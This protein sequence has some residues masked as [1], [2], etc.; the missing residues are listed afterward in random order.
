MEAT[1]DPVSGCLGKSA[2]KVKAVA[3]ATAKRGRECG[4]GSLIVYRC[5]YCRRWHIGTST[6]ANK[7]RKLLLAAAALMD[8]AGY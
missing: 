4:K 8:E 3:E 2:F 1:T 7:S 5:K 6:A